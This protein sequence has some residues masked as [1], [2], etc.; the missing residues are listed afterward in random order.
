MRPQLRTG[1]LAAFTLHLGAFYLG[2]IHTPLPAALVPEEPPKIVLP[3]RPFPVDPPEFDVN[4]IE[5]PIEEA[6]PVTPDRPQPIRDDAPVIDLDPTPPF[7]PTLRNAALV[8]PPGP[9][10]TGAGS[11]V[12]SIPEVDQAPQPIFQAPPAYP[13]AMRRQGIS[14]EVVLTFVVSANG[15]VRD[16]QVRSASRREFEGP[17][18]EALQRWKFRPGRRDGQP[19]SVRMELPLYFRIE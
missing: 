4:A 13:S 3:L 2:Q 9:V 19:V 11:P 7:R 17:A 16:V 1:A 15:A 10:S 18:L 6:I 8:I 12:F 14:G 5:P